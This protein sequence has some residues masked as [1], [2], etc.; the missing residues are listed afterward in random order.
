M[1]Y[2]LFH[3]LY[4]HR[5]IEEVED[6][7][8][9]AKRNHIL[10][11]V[12]R[13]KTP[14]QIKF[15]NGRL[16]YNVRPLLAKH[17]QLPCLLS[18]YDMAK[19]PMTV[20]YETKR[21]TLGKSRFQD[22]L[23]NYPE[24]KEDLAVFLMYNETIKPFKE[25]YLPVRIED[26][27]STIDTLYIHGNEDYGLK[28]VDT[29]DKLR[30]NRSSY[31]K[32]MNPSANT[33]NLKSGSQIGIAKSIPVLPEDPSE[34]K[35]T[36]MSYKDFKKKM[37]KDMDMKNNRYLTNL[38]KEEMIQLLW[39]YKHAISLGS[40]DI[41]KCSE[42]KCKIP[43]EE[44]KTFKSHCRPLP[45]NLRDNFK[46]QL[47]IWIEKGIV[48]KVHDNCPFSSPLVPVKKKNGQI[49]WA[50][51]YRGL[52]RITRKDHRPIPNVFERL[53]ALKAKNR[54]PLR[55]YGCLD[56]QDA[57]HNIEIDPSDQHKTAVTTPF[58]L[59]KFLRLPYGLHGA[60]QIFSEMILMLEERLKSD[61]PL[62]EQILIYF[63]DCLLCASTWEEFMMVLEL[64]FKHL[65]KMNLKINP[66]KCRLGLPSIKWLGH[67][68][69]DAG[70][71][72]AK[73]LTETIKKW[74]A[75][76]NIHQMRALYGT[77]SYYRRFIKD[78]THRT[79][80]M[81]KLL[82]GNIDFK[83][84]PE[85]DKEL[86]DMKEAMCS[87]PILGHPDFSQEANPF[88]LYVDSSK[89]GVGAI[90]AQEQT[91]QHEGK[92]LKTEV[93]IAFGS[94]ALTQGE[95]HYGSYKLE[96]LG[97]VYALTHF[98]YYL[99]GKKFIVCTD[100]KALEWILHTKSENIPSLLY[101]W[102]SILTDY[103]FEIR[104]LPG[105]QMKHVDGIS[106]MGY[107]SNYRGNMEDL[108]DFEEA[109]T[110]LSDDFWIPRLKKKEVNAVTTRS[111]T[112]LAE[113]PEANPAP[114]PED[115]PFTE[116]LDVEPE[117][118]IVP[119]ETTED[120]MDEQEEVTVQETD[121]LSP[122]DKI[123]QHQLQDPILGPLFKVVE[124]NDQEPITLTRYRQ[125]MVPN[126]DERLLTKQHSRIWKFLK[127]IKIQP[128]MNLLVIDIAVPEYEGTNKV[129]RCPIL[130][131][132]LVKESI[133]L[134][135]DH[136]IH[137]G[138]ERTFLILKD[139]VWFPGM[140]QAI[141]T[142]VD[143]CHECSQKDQGPN[144]V[145]LP[146][147]HTTSRPPT[148]LSRWSL[149]IFS[150]G[151]NTNKCLLTILDYSTRWLEAYVLP[152]Q[153]AE[154]T[155]SA[156]LNQFVPRFGKG[157]EFVTDNGPNFISDHF[158][159]FCSKYGIRHTR[160]IPYHPE[161]SPVERVHRTINGYMRVLLEDLPDER[162]PSKIRDVLFAYRTTPSSVTKASPFYLVYGKHPV[163]E[164]DFKLTGTNPNRQTFS[165][166]DVNINHLNWSKKDESME[167]YIKTAVE[168]QHDQNEQAK[169][170]KKST[171]LIIFQPGDQ[172]DIWRPQDVNPS[173]A[174][175]MIRHW[176][177]PY[178]VEK[179]DPEMPHRVTVKVKD[180]LK[181]VYINH[182]RKHIPKKVQVKANEL[183]IPQPRPTVTYNDD[184]DS[185][186][187]YD[188]I[189]D[190]PAPL[191]PMR[192]VWVP[193]GPI[194]VAIQG[195]R[196]QP[197]ATPMEVVRDPPRG[198]MRTPPDVPM[199]PV[200]R[201]SKR[202]L[203][204]P[205]NIPDSKTARTHS[206]TEESILD[207]SIPSS[208]YSSD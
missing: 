99:L 87:R 62:S 186:D 55:Y 115:E 86:A 128:G 147:G 174:Q 38:Q 51:D 9:T 109:Q 132:S 39:R 73:E 145:T 112:K 151:K 21:V 54:R 169:Q 65:S 49:R 48:E 143:S 34:T 46:Q 189:D 122:V 98:R 29:I 182:V 70:V 199:T 23:V 183:P 101:R 72:P 153:T 26:G 172:V 205:E 30:P 31:L 17:L 4:P 146:M 71:R 76:E 63:D 14:I 163:L 157:V 44:G 206:A 82:Q 56:L 184:D 185:D 123:R 32:V 69:S 118:D 57:F 207:I 176:T 178:I 139:R 20:N 126:G 120:G 64:F 113:Q 190:E 27:A 137:P 148:R 173:R 202:V 161:A 198:A 59:F 22:Q 200:M 194:N 129:R 47:D 116:E 41:G 110:S 201:Q 50:V 85:Q 88:I 131:A 52:N 144:R 156:L 136:Q 33:I 181:S 106:R 188:E 42:M 83:W 16:I 78:F 196:A 119:D 6:R 104:H 197:V 97:L 158:S 162:W 193:R 159:T 168:K 180:V 58:G 8:M 108:P 155:T 114:I 152:S 75:P 105:T 61:D 141:K 103:N 195:P 96:L 13:P 18:A 90:L 24:E 192:I 102:Q 43:T 187:D 92:P 130:P 135:H 127:L 165:T 91:N 80:A 60:P 150:I 95:R 191:T 175:K 140:R 68:I 36:N 117:A 45:P 84:G 10:K 25:A 93:V 125:L 77:L 81:R 74:P 35:S 167:Q 133:Q 208:E 12:G 164:V 179:H 166:D 154:A 89:N 28:M 37:K 94:K 79:A 204:S 40:A 53:S 149:D 160:T 3:Q 100:N 111:K 107:N 67:E 1:Q 177:G 170:S 2:E 142:Y 5:E 121:Q 124:E 138:N 171:P 7:I 19:L 15:A 203:T 134:A 66:T 11:I